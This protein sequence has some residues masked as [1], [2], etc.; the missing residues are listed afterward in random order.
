MSWLDVW[1]TEMTGNT[2]E[3]LVWGWCRKRW[4]TDHK[5]DCLDKHN[6]QNI[7]CVFFFLLVWE[8][9]PKPLNSHSRW[10]PIVLP[11]I[12]ESAQFVDVWKNNLLL[13]FLCYF[14]FV[15][16]SAHYYFNDMLNLNVL[17]ACSRIVFSRNSFHT[18][19]RP[20]NIITGHWCR[21]SWLTNI[22]NPKASMHG[23]Q[24]LIWFISNVNKSNQNLL[25]V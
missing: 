8:S 10:D 11:K 18:S 15:L 23:K 14:V 22:V 6:I 2:D 16:F 19:N 12:E 21:I 17:W 4:V 24:V 20:C 5:Q 1:R 9:W 13:V 7:F 3:G 25:S